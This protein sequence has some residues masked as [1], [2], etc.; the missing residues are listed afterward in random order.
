M[1]SACEPLQTLLCQR[2]ESF[3]PATVDPRASRVVH[4]PDLNACPL[5]DEKVDCQAVHLGYAIPVNVVPLSERPN[6]VQLELDPTAELTAVSYLIAQNH[7][8]FADRMAAT[9]KHELRSQYPHGENSGDE[10]IAAIA[11]QIS[12]HAE[13]IYQSWK[14]R[15]L[16][17]SEILKCH[18]TSNMDSKFSSTSSNVKD[19]LVQSPD[20]LEKLVSDFVVEDKA[21][22]AA[23]AATSNK[24]M[25][26]LPS[27]IQFALQKFENNILQNANDHKSVYGSQLRNQKAPANSFLNSNAS[28]FTDKIALKTRPLRNRNQIFVETIEPQNFGV[29]NNKKETNN[30]NP[31]VTQVGAWPLKNK[32]LNKTSNGIVDGKDDGCTVDS[33]YMDLVAREEKRLIDALKTGLV[34]AV[35]NHDKTQELEPNKS[36]ITS[37]EKLKFEDRGMVKN[38]AMKSLVTVKEKVQKDVDEVDSCKVVKDEK[39]FVS[40]RWGPRVNA[41]KP[42]VEVVPHPELTV[43]QKQNIRSAAISSS[44]TFSNPVRPFLTRGS[45][46]ERVMIFEK[47]PSELFLD[48][49]SPRQTG[50]NW[51]NNVESENKLQVSTDSKESSKPILPPHTTLQRHVKSNKSV[52]IPR[53]AKQVFFWCFV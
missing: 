15:G 9:A 40:S 34:L 41:V 48:K 16:A 20:H 26:H 24:N 49:R 27:S 30:Q 18:A 28:A 19:L 13:A 25:K 39:D 12:D 33:S 37:K 36:L 38:L 7:P 5:R 31:V 14:S 1:P 3:V 43:Q 35:D 11:K 46:A 45:V 22:I 52:H 23:A 53:Y 8:F 51:V 32:L 6:F 29:N 17:P 21:R 2:R 10:D 47:C 44:G 50:R 42:K 4:F